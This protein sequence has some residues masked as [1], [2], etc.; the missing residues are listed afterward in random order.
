MGPQCFCSYLS[1]Y[2]ESLNRYQ[3]DIIKYISSVSSLHCLTELNINMF[4]NKH[5]KT[6]VHET[7][8]C[9]QHHVKKKESSIFGTA[10]RTHSLT[11]T[12]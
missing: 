6:C 11:S 12:N 2:F 9:K 3:K 7:K 5:K 8:H 4:K 10:P 1:A